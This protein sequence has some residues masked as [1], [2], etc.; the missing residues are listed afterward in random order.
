MFRR[1]CRSKVPALAL[2]LIIGLYYFI[3]HSSPSLQVSDNHVKQ[4]SFQPPNVE[5]QE[6]KPLLKPE[7]AS[8]P[9]IQE[10]HTTRR[11]PT[12]PLSPIPT[13]SP[14][15]T[16]TSTRTTSI[17]TESLKTEKAF[18]PAFLATIANSAAK[19]SSPT[20]SPQATTTSKIH[21]KPSK[22]HYPIP[23]E[24]II[25]LPTGIPK[26]LPPVQAKFD[27][28]ERPEAR[29]KRIARKEQVKSEFLHAWN[30]YKN[31][32]FFHDEVRPVSG[33]THDPFGG[34]AA[35]L[36]DALDTLWIMG[37]TTEFEYAVQAVEK[38]DFTT[39]DGGEIRV[40]ETT[41]RYLGGFLGAYDISGHKYP[42]LLKKAEELAEILYGVFDTPNR[43]PILSYGWEP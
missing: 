21:W 17:A 6:P 22:E 26:A 19:Q 30:G 5:T 29:R 37:L 14:K 39:Y 43:M 3:F 25:P 23:K 42:T 15:P 33:A 28:I 41:I 12:K 36:V 2:V 7:P 9:P 11:R 35:T 16:T 40:F 8:L 13:T 4:S 31:N 34:W 1:I 38:L 24:S 18:T 20:L 10:I 27:K 32:A